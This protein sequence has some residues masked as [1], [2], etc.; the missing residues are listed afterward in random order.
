MG[1]ELPESFG[2]H[3]HMR[4]PNVLLAF[5]TFFGNV[6]KNSAYNHILRRNNE[7]GNMVTSCQCG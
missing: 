3:S 7:Y 2:P 4:V 1:Y 5:T 6:L